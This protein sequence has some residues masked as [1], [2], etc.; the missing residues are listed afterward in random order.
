MNPTT[1]KIFERICQ[2][3]R[4][5]IP[6]IRREIENLGSVL[7]AKD[8][9]NE[10][11]QM[12][13]LLTRYIVM[14]DA[15]QHEVDLASLAALSKMPGHTAAQQPQSAFPASGA[16]AFPQ[17]DAPQ[18]VP[19]ALNVIVGGPTALPLNL[20]NADPPD[21]EPANVIQTVTL[22]NGSTKVIPPI[23]SRA[24]SRTFA[25]G[26]PVD[27]TYIA[28]MDNAPTGDGAQPAG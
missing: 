21:P 12:I 9:L 15:E 22:R 20:G 8:R 7:S 14:R 26:Q 16:I 11:A 13:A 10:L 27:T 28:A 23:G 17:A 4:I 19:P 25:P 24:P 6:L 3:D 1:K 5:D 2:L 18:A